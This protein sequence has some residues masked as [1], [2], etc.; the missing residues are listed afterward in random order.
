MIIGI[1][2]P[3]FIAVLGGIL[4]YGYINDVR[5]RQ[6][7][8][9]LADNL[10]EQVLEVRRNEKNFLHYK[11]GDSLNGLNNAIN[12]LNGAVD[13]ISPETSKELGN[14]EISTVEE[15]LEK[16]LRLTGELDKSFRQETET[17]ERVR[18]EGA[19]LEKFIATRKHAKE[20]STDFILRLR[21][22]EKNYMFYRDKESYSKLDKGLLQTRNITPLC[23]ECIPYI[24]SVH[25]LF[26]KYKKSDSLI[27]SL[28][29]AGDRLEETTEEIAVRE[30]E[31]INSFIANTMKLLFA[32]LVLLFILGPLF[33]YKTASYIVA[34]IKRLAEITK[35]ISKGDITVRA[36]LKEQDET[37]SLAVSFN[38]MLDNLQNT[39]KSLKE[40]I[41][42]LNEKQAQLVESEKRASMGFLVAGVAH[43]LNN[44]LNNISLRAEIV[45]EEI[46]KFSDGK[47]DG[48]V[49][50]IVTQSQR[51]HKIINNLLD[52]ARARKSEGMEKQDITSIVNDS[53]NLVENQLKI[54]NINL[55]K[56]IPDRP[57]YVNGNRSKIEQV[58]ISIITNAI[59]AM[60]G[61]GALTVSTEA[62]TEDRNV[63]IRISDTGKGIPEADIKN[64][65]E[66]FFTTKPPGEGTGLGL[67]VSHTLVTEHQGEIDV[68]SGPDS[69]TT[70]TIKLPL[71]KGPS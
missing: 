11:S 61:G 64:I 7:F 24:D 63:L 32:A 37:Y 62:D 43:E 47:L 41:E 55:I 39:Q 67:A 14:S 36:P 10:K 27:V 49:H 33:V 26:T 34:P 21:L 46:R 40:N 52:F 56:D 38:T 13:N 58:L 23:Y 22:L 3:S 68:K 48:Y 1:S 50:D 8:V 29:T 18:A 15:L 44:P 16:Y 2:I 19:R 5:S 25:A 28:Q 17:A 12:A 31:K 51:A 65:F 20:L 59:Q 57:F 70:F 4:T 30:R 9:G 71:F 54:N 45:Q 69:G 35:R 60:E 66:P 53:F 42:L 6:G